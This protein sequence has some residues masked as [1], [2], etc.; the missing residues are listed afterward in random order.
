MFFKKNQKRG[1]EKQAVFDQMKHID[2]EDIKMAYND[3]NKIFY[4]QI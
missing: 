3:F 1:Y 2:I 4:I